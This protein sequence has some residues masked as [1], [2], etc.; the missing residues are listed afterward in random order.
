[1]PFSKPILDE[2][3]P[4]RLWANNLAVVLRWVDSDKLLKMQD[5][6]IY[7]L[8]VD[9]P[10]I[11]PF[12]KK[13][14]LDII[15]L[16][17]SSLMSALD[18]V[19]KGKKIAAFHFAEV[20]I[21]IKEES[22]IELHKVT[23]KHEDIPLTFNSVILAVGKR[24]A[25]P[26]SGV[27]VCPS[28][29]E[30]ERSYADKRRAL[31]SPLCLN[32][33][34]K[35][36][37]MEMKEGTMKSELVQD[38]VLQEPIEEILENQPVD[39]DAKIVDTDVGH[40]YMGQKK[41]ITGIFRV[42]Y[43]T[44]GKQK[45]IYIDVLT[46]KDLDDVELSLPSE[47][48]LH[49]WMNT[50]DEQLIENVISSFAPHIFGYKHIKLA[51][52]LA[53]VSKRDRVNGRR[54]G[55]VNNLLVGDPGMAKSMLLE[56]V[57]RVTQK[58]TFTTG[59]GSTAAGLTAGMVKRENGTSVLQ[60]GTYPL[61]HHG[62]AIVDEFDKMNKDD[63]G[64]MH[65]VMEQGKV[66]RSVAG[67]NVSLP[68]MAVTLAAANPKFG[69]YDD[70]L[71]LMENL[72]LPTPILTRFDLIFLI[73]DKVDSIMDAKKADKVLADFGDPTEEKETVY[74][75]KQMI[76]YLN[77]VQQLDVVLTI[78]AQYKLKQIYEKLRN[79]SKDKD[80]VPVTPRTLE[81]LGRLA[82]SH[83][84]LLFKNKADETDVLAV[85][86]LYKESYHSF[87]KELEESGSQLTLVKSDKLNK[88]QQFS[89]AWKKCENENKYVDEKDLY[90]LLEAEFN[91]ERKSSMNKFTQK[92]S[93][94]LIKKCANGR[95]RAT[96]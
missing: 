91:W 24:Q 50:S 13:F 30:E 33:S 47:S 68:A 3:Y 17:S 55:W 19:H 46:V 95:Y 84:K 44:K 29:Y 87:G 85:Y 52:L 15:E 69:N 65:E 81:S 25:Y 90:D 28:C 78:K 53:I 61:S 9:H 42:E 66:S 11:K 86:E 35:K 82:I 10:Y 70:S 77:Y 20:K 83:A 27:F 12:Y 37:K 76:S 80:S 1:M 71:T 4:D 88:E 5:G 59:K 23:T 45:D 6:S 21:K 8:D 89:K 16:T 92:Y 72:D 74:S 64:I 56:A 73:K 22:N 36:Q 31:K 62:V 63:M 18:T 34:C 2:V 7:Y 54:R 94:G 75:N 51:L 39:I 49:D 96:D 48:D 26:T 40:T 93:S 79:I 67:K 14:G 38:I 57:Q 43:D 58:S 60:A 41:K 32:P